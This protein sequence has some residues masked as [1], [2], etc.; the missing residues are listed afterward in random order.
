MLLHLRSAFISCLLFL[1]PQV[2]AQH[3]LRPLYDSLMQVS[4]QAAPASHFAA[5]YARSM[6]TY[7]AYMDAL[8]PAAGMFIFRFN[9][10]FT[11]RFFRASQAY[12]QQDSIPPEWQ[13][14]YR[15]DTLNMLQYQAMGMNS[16]INGDLWQ[17]LVLQPVDTLL[18]YKRLFLEYQLFFNRFADTLYREALAWRWPRRMH[19]LSMGAAR[20]VLRK[21]V[22]TWR[23]KQLRM[24]V[25]Y[26]RHPEKHRRMLHRAE[27]RYL[28][29]QRIA[30]KR[31]V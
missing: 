1:V 31:L 13:A 27:K 11:D 14:Y 26:Y 8:Q 24:A 3:A 25:A 5:L 2:W 29:Y 20:I 21:T 15:T 28:R 12:A 7:L 9:Q 18:K 22:Y 17:A 19:H 6:H 23:K 30:L 16:H 10:H 4:H